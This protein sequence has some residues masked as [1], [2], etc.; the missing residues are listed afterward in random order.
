[1]EEFRKDMREGAC[2]VV[3]KEEN[4]ETDFPEVR[5]GGLDRLIRVYG[6][7]MAAVYKWRKKTGA[8]G[9]VII[10]GAQLPS[11]KVFGY[12]SIQCLKAAE[13]FLLEKAQKDLKT[14]KMRSLNVDTVT[15]E[16]VNGIARKL[17]V[18]GSRGRNQIHGVYGQANLP[19]LTKEHK[20]SELYA[21]AAHEIGH[22]GMASTLHR[23][24]KRVWIIHG[25]AL[26][27]FVKSKCTE[28]R[29]KEK[30]C[31]EQKMGPLPDHR[32]QVGAMFQS[33][34]IDLFG[35]VEYQQHVKKRQV[36]KGWGVVF[37]CTTTSAL[38][39]EFMDTYST[40]SFL[41]ALRRF[42]SIRGTPTRFQSDRGEQLVAAAKQVAT[43]DFKEVVQWAG[44]R[45][46]E[47]TLV[48][49]GG[50]HFNGQAERMIGLIKQQLWRIF[51]GKRLSYEETLTV[52][53]EAVHKINSRPI[54]WN[55]RPEGKPLCV[56]DLMLGRAKPGQV[57][58]KLESGK[59]LAKR[60]ENVQQIQRDF[61]KRWIEEVFPERLKQSKWKQEKRDLKEGDIVLRKDETAAGQTYKYAKVVKVH[62]S[63]DGK[64]RAADIE[65][66]LPGEST[67][68]KTTRPIHKLVLIIPV[69][70]Q[71]SAAS[72]T[73]EVQ[74]MPL[75]EKMQEG[76][77]EEPEAAGQESSGLQEE[78]GP[79]EVAPRVPL[80]IRAPRPAIK[81]KKVISR[82]K[83]GK[84]ARTIVVTSPKEE[85]EMVD[86]G[87]GL[88]R[89]GGQERPPM[90]I[91]RIRTRGVS[92]TLGE[93]SVRIL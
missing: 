3:S 16:D 45:G 49:T 48:P 43:W 33:V 24:R 65:Y 87:I 28:C 85:A 54:T 83:A 11:G 27:D 23:T 40:D 42:M 56:Q 79:A 22:E 10:N 69:E 41:M 46:I 73:E 61:W 15:E 31:M 34:A 32:V 57:E 37:V 72:K 14:A 78:E 92:C 21:Q 4:S 59:K 76:A 39:V 88:E 47:W 9:P 60:F 38:H 13:L 84:Q 44:R 55:P 19:V 36:G 68:R 30:K 6:Y 5:K 80:R 63:T 71:V 66:K 25:R 74:P 17:V 64:V 90:W 51:E 50:Q 81:F 77:K 12:P 82:K 89:E 7:V 58:V 62:T 52:L 20:L 67:F 18:I 86:I 8:T 91:H 29:L 70:E 35:P 93:E 1:M 26:A 75:A 53:A 2:S